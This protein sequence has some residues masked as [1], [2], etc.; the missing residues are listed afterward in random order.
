MRPQKYRSPSWS[1]H[2]D[3]RRARADDFCSSFVAFTMGSSWGSFT[4][5]R[6][7]R[8]TSSSGPVNSKPSNAR[9]ANTFGVSNIVFEG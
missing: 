6:M 5:L 1:D 7:S 9:T 2:S 4:P 3:E 8:R